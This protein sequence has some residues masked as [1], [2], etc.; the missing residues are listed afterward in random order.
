MTMA[1]YDV[2]N[3]PRDMEV[4]KALTKGVLY[5][6]ALSLPLFTPESREEGAWVGMTTEEQAKAVL[7]G[8]V[9]YDRI[10]AANPGHIMQ[11]APP[12]P[13]PPFQ[14][15]VPEPITPAFQAPIAP[16]PLSPTPAIP[17][18]MSAG[19]P[20]FPMAPAQMAPPPLAGAP[21]AFHQTMPGQMQPGYMATPPA[22]MQMPA[23]PAQFQMPAQPIQFQQPMQ[24]APAFQQ[25]RQPAPAFQQPAQ[26]NFQQ[27]AQS[28]PMTQMQA[29][30]PM[31]PMNQQPAQVNRQPVTRTD[32]NNMGSSNV[33]TIGILQSLHNAL[34]RH[35]QAME[36]IENLLLGMAHIQNVMNILVFEVAE[37]TLGAP[38]ADLIKLIET[39]QQEGELSK[40]F[41]ST[42]G[43][44]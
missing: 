11:G 18:P 30:P 10:R 6:L 32:P 37:R 43:K 16:I 36:R 5:R 35:D 20:P 42:G 2:D 4:L 33:S 25:P 31:Q 13:P 1:M 17:A 27:P 41:E 26:G 39:S 8:L 7:A 44:K 38:K 40:L 28:H 22:P 24:Q 21:A 12:Q 9:E 34:V 29:P 14:P 19:G 15:V 3:V 23:Q